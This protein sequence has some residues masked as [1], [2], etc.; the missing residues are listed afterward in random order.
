M[1]RLRN[2]ARTLIAIMREIFDE[3]AYERF[4]QRNGMESGRASYAAFQVERQGQTARRVRC[5]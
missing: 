5:C 1:K 4:L 3:S 2:L